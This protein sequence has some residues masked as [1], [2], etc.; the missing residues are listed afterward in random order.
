MDSAVHGRVTVILP[1]AIAV[2]VGVVVAAD[3]I[4]RRL[5]GGGA[6]AGEW[7][8]DAPRGDLIGGNA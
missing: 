3:A 5:R 4:S 1:V 6:S 8:E 7:S 2:A